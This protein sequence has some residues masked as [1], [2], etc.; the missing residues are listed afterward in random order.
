MM[1]KIVLSCG[2]Q[3][4][5]FYHVHNVMTKAN[6]R[7]G[8]KAIAYQAVCGPCEDQYR[9]H[10]EIFDNYEDAEEWLEKEEW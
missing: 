9:Q 5:D 2:H 3:V 6:D 8:N 10:G 7:E 4:D 1:S